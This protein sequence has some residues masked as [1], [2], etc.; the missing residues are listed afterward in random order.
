[1]LENSKHALAKIINGKLTSIN[2][3]MG[4]DKKML[5]RQLLGKDMVVKFRVLGV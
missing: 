4:C 5:I 3:K 1:M 2:L